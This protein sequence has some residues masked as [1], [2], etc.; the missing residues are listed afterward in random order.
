MEKRKAP[1]WERESFSVRRKNLEQ[2]ARIVRAIRSFFDVSGFVEVQTPALQVSPGLEP[3]LQAF[4]TDLLDPNGNRRERRYLHTSPEFAMKKILAAGMERIYQISLV[5][6]NRERSAT[7]HP[8]F[9]MLEWYRAGAPYTVLMDDCEALLRACTKAAG[10]GKLLTWKGVTADPELPFERI[11]VQEAFLKYA[12][13][14][15]L[16]SIRDPLQPTPEGLR[17][18]CRNLG[19]SCAPD[20]SWEDLFF[21][22][23]LEKIEPNLGAG[24]PT[25]LYDYPISMAALSR[26]KAEATHL[27]ERFELYVCGLELANAFGELTDPRAQRVRFEADM[28][29]KQRLY[30]ERYP[31]DEDFLAALAFMPESS[32]IALGVDRLA[33]LITGAGQIEDVLWAPVAEPG[34]T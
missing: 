13:T 20:D 17:R 25:I 15:I 21:R 11:S 28:Q 31:L 24:R 4:S 9:S 2:R 14:D 5:Y 8:E 22:I 3:H 26:P 1:F 29:K 32:G 18:A 27:A 7:H 30:G 16:A 33:M 10:G 12:E 19:I 34:G 6:R 23:F